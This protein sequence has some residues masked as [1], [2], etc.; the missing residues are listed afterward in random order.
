MKPIIRMSWKNEPYT[1]YKCEDCCHSTTDKNEVHICKYT[2]PE[3]IIEAN[4]EIENYI[5]EHVSNKEIL[6]ELNEQITEEIKDLKRKENDVAKQNEKVKNLRK[7]IGDRE[8]RQEYT[9]GRSK[10]LYSIILKAESNAKLNDKL[11]VFDYKF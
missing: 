1:C 2:T 8:F 11:K 3:G 4:N 6:N 9:K 10:H 5:K 7:Q